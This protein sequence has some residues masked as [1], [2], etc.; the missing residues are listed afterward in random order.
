[1]KRK[2]L[3]IILLG[4]LLITKTSFGM[5]QDPDALLLLKSPKKVSTKVTNYCKEIIKTLNNNELDENTRETTLKQLWRDFF[6]K[7]RY[8]IKISSRT[9]ENANKLLLAG[10]FC[11]AHCLNA[12]STEESKVYVNEK[13][14]LIYLPIHA[15][16]KNYILQ[17]HIPDYLSPNQPIREYV[18][19]NAT[20]DTVFG[21]DI[22]LSGPTFEKK[23][24]NQSTYISVSPQP[25]KY[26]KRNFFRNMAYTG[27][28]NHNMNY[29]NKYLETIYNNIPPQWRIDSEKFY[30][31]ILTWIL[32]FMGNSIT[33]PEEATAWGRID[34]VVLTRIGTNI[35]EFKRNRSTKEALEQVLRKKYADSLH[36]DKPTYL[37]GINVN[38][39]TDPITVTCDKKIYNPIP[40]SPMKSQEKMQQ[41]TQK[42]KKAA[43]DIGTSKFSLPKGKRPSSSNKK[44]PPIDKKRKVSYG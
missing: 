1:M 41:F 36:T 26:T 5:E 17:F 24:N 40:A 42:T 38:T 44:E 27:F 7:I 32:I 20:I 21:I 35:V 34:I 6:S 33:I 2:N 13:D 43:N 23:A 31:S 39:K 12:N 28:Y 16:N 30:Q 11:I 3:F 37:I 10:F 9:P 15:N 18:V 19:E 25:L 22:N 29:L 8:T 4:I 14:N